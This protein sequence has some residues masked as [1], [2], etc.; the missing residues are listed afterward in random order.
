MKPQN[1]QQRKAAAHAHVYGAAATLK[2]PTCATC[3][4]EVVWIGG[5]WYHARAPERRFVN[6]L[7]DHRARLGQGRMLFIAD[8]NAEADLAA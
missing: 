1:T 3:N 8:Y 4:E 2:I 7:H 6:S 5:D